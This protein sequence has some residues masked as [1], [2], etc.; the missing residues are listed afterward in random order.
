MENTAISPEEDKSDN[1]IAD[2][3]ENTE[4]VLDL[5]ATI[6]YD[7]LTKEDSIGITDLSKTIAVQMDL[8]HTFVYGI[9]GAFVDAN[10]ELVM[11]VGKGGGVQFRTKYEALQLSRQE[12]KDAKT[13]S[14]FSATAR[15]LG[16]QE[17]QFKK[18]K[19]ELLTET[20]TIKMLKEWLAKQ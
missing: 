5:A 15:E 3:I 6:I 8:K 17:E 10:Q 7:T 14:K 11:G 12:A 18:A 16:F 2:V 4:K 1:A 9:I 13:L 19:R 20:P